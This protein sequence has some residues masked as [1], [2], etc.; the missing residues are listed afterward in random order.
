MKRENVK[1]LIKLINLKSEE[2]AKNMSEL[3]LVGF[4]ELILQLGHFTHDL[5][6]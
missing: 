5:S 4:T 3:D 2:P 6:E 1:K